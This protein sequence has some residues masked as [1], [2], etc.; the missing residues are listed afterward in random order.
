MSDHAGT[1][2]DAP[3]HFDSRSGAQSVEQMPLED[4]YTE[5]FCLDLSH[6]PL[7]HAI[8]IPEMEAALAKSGQLFKPRDTVLLWMGVE[9]RLLGKPGYQHD[10]PGL[11]PESVHWLA[12]QG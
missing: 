4:F 1:H 6:V 5:A 9:Q 11:A 10:F 12:D 3:V 8:T 7:G 2:V